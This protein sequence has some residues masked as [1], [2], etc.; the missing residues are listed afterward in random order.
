MQITIDLMQLLIALLVLAGIAVC[1]VLFILLV[2]LIGMLKKSEGLV[3]DATIVM[4]SASR[5]VPTILKDA[6]V[7]SS[8][9][10]SGVEAIGG[11]ARSVGEGVSS[12]FGSEEDSAAGT[13]ETVFGIVDRI[14]A[15]IGLFTGGR[16]KKS[17]KK[18]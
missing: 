9:T 12:L 14:L 17:R 11:A 18:R 15:I 8:T 5:S 4:A 2:R 10:R 13:V 16:K 6:E 1:I 7:I 3:K